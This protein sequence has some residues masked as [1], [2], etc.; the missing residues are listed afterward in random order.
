MMPKTLIQSKV[1]LFS[2]DAVL[3]RREY[4]NRAYTQ[5]FKDLI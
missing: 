5:T 1:F 2:M 3:K 4:K